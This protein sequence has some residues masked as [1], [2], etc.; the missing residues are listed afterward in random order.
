MLE[1]SIFRNL[2]WTKYPIPVQRAH[3]CTVVIQICATFL[4]LN[5]SKPGC[6]SAQ[7]LEQEKQFAY[8]THSKV[9]ALNCELLVT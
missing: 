9:A 4:A 3:V 7:K 2:F 8:S 6:L 5:L 1:I